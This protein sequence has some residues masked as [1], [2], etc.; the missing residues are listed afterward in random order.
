MKKLVLIAITFIL[1]SC[2]GGGGNSNGAQNVKHKKKSRGDS[3]LSRVC[4]AS[5]TNRTLERLFS[6]RSLIDGKISIQNRI[7]FHQGDTTKEYSKT[8]DGIRVN[9]NDP[10]LYSQLH[11]GDPQYFQQQIVAKILPSE[12]FLQFYA[13]VQNNYNS[14]TISIYKQRIEG[15]SCNRF[16]GRTTCSYWRPDGGETLLERI[17]LSSCESDDD[18]DDE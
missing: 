12:E 6:S 13:R 5:S 1:S 18:D 7:T 4:S 15:Q 16:F 8:F 17:E 10:R 2:G 11:F 14:R 9:L 3:S